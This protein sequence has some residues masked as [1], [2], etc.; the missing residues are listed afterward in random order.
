MTSLVV[1][2]SNKELEITYALPN[3]LLHSKKKINIEDKEQILNSDVT[4]LHL[5]NRAMNCLKKAGIVTV[6]ELLKYTKED[7]LKFRTFG[8]KS[9]NEVV[10]TLLMYGLN[11]ASE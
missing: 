4:E 9:I 10:E 3:N 7:L 1:T 6:K 5:T 2:P 11:L 8:E